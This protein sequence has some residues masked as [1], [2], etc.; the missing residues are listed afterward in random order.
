MKGVSLL[1]QTGYRGAFLSH[2]EKLFRAPFV[3]AQVTN[4]LKHLLTDFIQNSP[5]GEAQQM[6]ASTYA[7]THYEPRTDNAP[8]DKLGAIVASDAAAVIAQL[9]AKALPIHKRYSHL[10]GQLHSETD[11]SALYE[12]AAEIVEQITPTLTAI[13]K[14]IDHIKATGEVPTQN[15]VDDSKKAVID[16]MLK[17]AS[18]TSRVSRLKGLI[19]K[20]ETDLD[21]QTYQKELTEKQHE[22]AELNEWLGLA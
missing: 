2:A 21:K 4:R 11:E 17:R 15:A 13:Y 1:A 6:E 5:V 20:A 14:Q 18:L 22:L 8:S 9:K 7:P 12:V 16:A 3:P 10:K 19:R